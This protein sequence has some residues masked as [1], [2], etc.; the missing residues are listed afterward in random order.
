MRAGATEIYPVWG[1]IPGLN[2]QYCHPIIYIIDYT[3]N[4]IGYT[5]ECAIYIMHIDIQYVTQ[6][7]Y[8]ESTIF[9]HLSFLIN[10]KI[11]CLHKN[12][13][14][15]RADE[16]WSDAMDNLSQELKCTVDTDIISSSNKN[17]AWIACIVVMIE[18]TNPINIFI[19]RKLSKSFHCKMHWTYIGHTFL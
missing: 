2:D 13:D 1:S 12:I 16:A 4:S 18:T 3:I 19:F 17:V 9:I 11:V 10:N 6:W 14:K 15:T 7:R 8:G 5:M